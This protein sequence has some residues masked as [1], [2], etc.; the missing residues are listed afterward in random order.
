M[1]AMRSLVGVNNRVSVLRRDF[2]FEAIAK[3]IPSE[4]SGDAHEEWGNSI[5]LAA[6]SSK[7][8]ILAC[9]IE[10]LRCSELQDRGQ[11]RS[12]Q[13]KGSR[14]L[15][16]NVIK[17]GPIQMGSGQPLFL[18]AGPCVVEG[19]DAC[20]ELARSLK[21]VASQADVP[22]IFKASFDKANRSS[23]NSF[24]GIGFK[25]GLTVLRKI[26][27]ELEVPVLTDI[28]EPAQA[29]L[30]AEFVDIL[31]IPALLCR[32][33]DL[34]IAA[35][36][37][38]KVV[39]IKKGQFVA[40]GDMGHACQK[41]ASTGNSNIL[42]T[43]RGTSFGYRYLVN[44]FRGI[45]TMQECGYPV[46]F[47][48]THSV[49]MPGGLGDKSGGER[50][51]VAVLARAAVAAGADG[52]FFEAHADPDKALSD[53]PNMLPVAELGEVLGVLKRIH[54]AVNV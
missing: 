54:Q 40:P 46:V 42:L 35:G 14:A 17:V 24:R 44:D 45:P 7:H 1:E 29:E 39:N 31:Q 6:R 33:T 10:C 18:I 19:A 25:E 47:D 21:A 50:Q 48:A 32:Q 41:V 37:T 13:G 22:F 20:F 5:I 12:G 43:E 8:W 2:E 36:K 15:K 38:G 52:V 3:K 11:A 49:Q 28:H 51:F 27:D 16:R 30:V 34:L 9:D 26:R 23:V 4:I 53:G